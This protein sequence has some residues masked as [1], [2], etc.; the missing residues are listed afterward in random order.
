MF[1]YLLNSG[2][3]YGCMIYHVSKEIL[4]TSQINVSSNACRGNVSLSEA[5]IHFRWMLIERFTFAIKAWSFTNF[6]SIKVEM[7]HELKHTHTRNHTFIITGYA[8]GCDNPFPFKGQPKQQV[9]HTV[10]C[11]I[12]PQSSPHP[13]SPYQRTALPSPNPHRRT[14]DLQVLKII[15]PNYLWPRDWSSFV[16]QKFIP[17]RKSA[18]R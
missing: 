1:Y 14:M 11:A 8:I 5:L 13:V 7:L 6:H 16:S 10:H 15:R 12:K 17:E 4:W 9:L 18:I 3:A 2:R